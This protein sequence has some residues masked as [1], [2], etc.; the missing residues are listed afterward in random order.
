VEV[1]ASDIVETGVVDLR[2]A[3][4]SVHPERGKGKSKNVRTKAIA[5]IVVD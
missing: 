3:L 1:T 5:I 4:L 2:Y